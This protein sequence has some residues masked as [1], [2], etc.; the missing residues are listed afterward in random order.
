LRNL[1]YIFESKIIL[2]TIQSRFIF[3][4]LLFKIYRKSKWCRDTFYLSI[5]TE[6]KGNLGFIS[7][8]GCRKKKGGVGW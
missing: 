8:M 6:M 5:T 2:W 1:E 3:W 7:I 4:I